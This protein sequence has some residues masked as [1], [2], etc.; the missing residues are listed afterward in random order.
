MLIQS[1]NC[2]SNVRCWYVALKSLYLLKFRKFFAE[3]Y[4]RLIE[5]SIFL[6]SL[7][8][9]SFWSLQWFLCFDL[10]GPCLGQRLSRCFFLWILFSFVFF[11]LACVVR[12]ALCKKCPYSVLFWSVL[13]PNEGKYGPELVRIQ[14]FFTQSCLDCFELQSF[15]FRIRSSSSFIFWS[16]FFHRV[17]VVEALHNGGFRLIFAEL[18]LVAE[19]EISPWF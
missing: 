7:I 18:L 15:N 19:M 9:S 4:S 17:S 2:Y 14:T 6:R 13:N 16:L 1:L 3:S 11:H 10:L 8:K 12:V 5:F